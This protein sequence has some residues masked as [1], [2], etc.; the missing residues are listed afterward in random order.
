MPASHVVP[1]AQP[2]QLWVQ[3]IDEI[4]EQIGR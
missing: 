4:A 1:G 3:L 2:T